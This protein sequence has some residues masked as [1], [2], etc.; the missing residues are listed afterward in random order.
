MK[1][2]N[3]TKI[4]TLF[5]V[6]TN[7]YFKGF[8][9]G[10][11]YMGST[12]NLCVPG[13]NCYSCP[14]AL[15]SCPLG[16]LQNVFASVTN[17]ISLYMIGVFLLFGSILGRLVC[18]YLCPF[19]LFQELLYKIKLFKKKKTMPFHKILIYLKHIILVFFVIL[20]PLFLT[21]RF[22]LGSPYFCK[23]ICP[24]GTLLAG[25]PLVLTNKSIAASIGSLFNWK[26]SLLIII[27]LLSI[28]YIR[29]FCKYICP[30]GAIYG[31]FNPIALYHFNIDN[32][33]C[34]SCNRCHKVCPMDIKT[35]QTP[36][37][38]ECIRCNK[39]IKVCP[40]NALSTSFQKQTNKERSKVNG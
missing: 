34:I 8:F 3:R 39:C 25:I 38:M 27:T 23:Y 30:L 26:I 36:N 14:G 7:S 29:P 11:I 33:K 22:G 15:G 24:S 16:S 40:T 17:K 28:K 2:D 5:T 1:I 12:K 6:A 9:K 35:Y 13:L 37:S 4:Q 20:M 21:N 19:G 18:G 10:K 31:Y 32:N